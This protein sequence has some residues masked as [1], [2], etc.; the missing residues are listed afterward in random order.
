MFL[1]FTESDSSKSDLAG[2]LHICS[3]ALAI[4]LYSWHI[5]FSAYLVYLIHI[6]QAFH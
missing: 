5:H 2:A 1:V 4:L 6:L 3:W